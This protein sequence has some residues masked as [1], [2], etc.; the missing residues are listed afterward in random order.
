MVRIANSKERETEILDRLIE[1]YIQESHPISSGY[2]QQK[3]NLPYSSATI[4]NVMVSLED[5]GLIFHVHTSSGRVPT[6][7]GFR[8]YVEHLM[9]EKTMSDY[10]VSLTRETGGEPGIEETIH[11]TLDVLAEES[12]YTSLFAFAERRPGSGDNKVFFHGMRF[13]FNQPEFADII[14][15]K[16]LFYT[17]EVKINQLQDLLLRSFDD[18]VNILIGDEL[19]LEE[20]ADC[21]LV[22]SGAREQD[23]TFS[24]GLLGPMR[25]DYTKASSCLYS[26]KNQLKKIIEE[27]L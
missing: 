13:I 6:Q 21:A 3:Y 4:R 24:L 20:I 11:H 17:L 19:G 18:R 26:I 5:K 22:I 14:R 23:L 27:S 1:S 25:M 9:Y 8:R 10:P 15:L 2:L 12:G 7:E 16:N